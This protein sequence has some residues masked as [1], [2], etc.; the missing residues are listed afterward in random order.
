MNAFY[1]FLSSLKLTV[2]LLSCSIVLVFFGTLDQVNWGIWEVKSHYFDAWF[3]TWPKAAEGA[4]ALRFCLPMPGG[5]TLGV[6]LLA[7]LV[8]AHFRHFRPR[9]G[10]AGITLIHAGVVV[11]LAGGFASAWLQEEFSL[12]IPEGRANDMLAGRH[13]VASRKLPFALHLEKFTHEYHPG[14]RIGKNF[15]STVRILEGGASGADEGRRV[16]ISMNEPLRHGGYTFYQSQFRTGGGQGGGETT[17]LQVVR[18]PG[19]LLPYVAMYLGGAG[20]VVQFLLSLGRFLKRPRRAGAMA[21]VALLA[22]VVPSGAQ[23][24]R[25]GVPEAEEQAHHAGD[26][27]D[28]GRRGVLPPALDPAASTV[29]ARSTAVLLDALAGFPVQYNG[30]V[31]PVDTLA[32]NALLIMGGRQTVA[33]SAAEAVAFGKKPSAWDEGDRALMAAE[34]IALSGMEKTLL[35]VR[36]VALRKNLFGRAS[37]PPVTFLA[38]LAFRPSIAAH[39]RVFRVENAEVRALFPEKTGAVVYFS[40]KEVFPKAGEINRRLGEQS[41]GTPFGRGMSKLVAAMNLYDVLSFTFAPGD[42]PVAAS[43][44]EEYASWQNVLVDAARDLAR[45]S[46]KTGAPV[47]SNSGVGR[48]VAGFVQRYREMA[49]GGRV[50]IVPPRTGEEVREGRWANLGEAL[51]ALTQGVDFEGMPVVPLYG[52]LRVAYER[53]DTEAETAALENLGAVF[54]KLAAQGALPAGKLE[55]ER[56]FN[57]VEPFFKILC[58][59]V[60]V[61]LLVC[62]GWALN[63]RRVLACVRWAVSGVFVLHTVALFARMWV[64]GRPPVTNLYSSAVFVAWGAVLVGL[65]TERFLRNGIGSAVAA[66]VG[67][68]SLIIAHHLSMGG[69]TVKTMEAVLDSNFLL[70]V[71]VVPITLGYSAMFVA[72]LLAAL[73]LVL[74]AA[75]RAPRAQAAAAER[76]VY[77]VVCFATLLTFMGTMLGGVWADQSWGRFWGWD[78]KENGAL[79]IVLWCAIFLHAR[80]GRLL[81]TTGLMQLAVLGNVITAASWFGTNL[82]GI[83]LHSYGFSDKGFLWLCAFWVSQLLVFSLGWIP[84]RKSG[85]GDAT[86]GV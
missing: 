28:H 69:D 38:E 5:F 34:G 13:G 52:V 55:A 1:R 6:L 67:F 68:A 25:P 61:F 49:K 76:A 53:G 79:V 54:S 46:E 63:S 86:A 70:T 60:G 18:N 44:E 80:W 37:V 43:P 65:L 75:G 11:L 40:W 12:A 82:L 23:P 22:G 3:A 50:G 66:M 14:T 59:Y 8:C 26:G 20:M 31:Q 74:R 78:P 36:P 45:S 71:H 9:W 32:R 16:I 83:G 42:T 57:R 7:N 84:E 19:R 21:A 48:V 72:G 77:G 58:C 41:E 73:W 2:F 10:K 33:L 56:A 81:G 47:M 17:I 30:R 64:E 24:W 85:K 4:P 27:H 62:L 51:M 35:E 15:A 39:F 29:T